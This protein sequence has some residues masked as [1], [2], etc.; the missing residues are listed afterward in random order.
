MHYHLTREWSTC[1]EFLAVDPRSTQ[2]LT[3]PAKCSKVRTL[4]TGFSQNVPIT[5]RSVQMCPSL[6]FGGGGGLQNAPVTGGGGWR[7]NK[8][9]YLSWSSYKCAHHSGIRKTHLFLISE[10]FLVQRF[11]VLMSPF[12][13][14]K[15]NLQWVGFGICVVYSVEVVC[16]KWPKC[17]N[18]CTFGN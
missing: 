13:S 9:D 6:F 5:Q 8:Y 16:S 3:S 18:K 7:S 10:G 1:R 17:C 11:W 12:L 14:E 15:I 4:N 2:I